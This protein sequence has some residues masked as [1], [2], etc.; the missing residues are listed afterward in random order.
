MEGSSAICFLLLTQRF[1]PSDSAIF[2]VYS[3]SEFE[4]NIT[5]TIILNEFMSFTKSKPSIVGIEMSSNI[6]SIAEVVRTEIASLVVNDISTSYPCL[7][8]NILVIFKVTT[9][10]SIKSNR[11]L[12]CSVNLAR[13]CG[14]N[15]A[16]LKG[17]KGKSCDPKDCRIIPTRVKSGH[18]NRIESL[19]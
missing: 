5:G 15:V 2:T 10:S 19:S 4:R 8:S 6:K 17:H 11:R 9:S 7:S 16:R 1:T 12:I 3:S 14:V 13:K 18:S